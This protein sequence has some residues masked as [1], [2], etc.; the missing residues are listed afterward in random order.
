M[1]SSHRALTAQA[2]TKRRKAVRLLTGDARGEGDKTFSPAQQRI[3]EA[4]IAAG[5]QMLF[6][7]LLE[8]SQASASTVQT[9]EKRGAVEV[10]VSGQA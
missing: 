1:R 8:Q 10:I 9:L 6:A 5:G 3:I 2:K 7:D 4:L